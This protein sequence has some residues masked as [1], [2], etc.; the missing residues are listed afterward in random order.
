M[1]T[2]T[3]FF[4]NIQ[5]S[6]SYII[7]ENEN[8][9]F[10]MLDVSGPQ[11]IWFHCQKYSSCHVIVSLD[12]HQYTDLSKKEKNTIVKRGA[13]LCKFHTLKLRSLHNLVFIFTQVQNIKK[14]NKPGNVIIEEV[15]TIIL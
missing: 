2:E 7:S 10:K 14:T 15:K 6:F 8:E 12:K 3:I 11:D 1:K 13:F 5:K 9:P 4:K